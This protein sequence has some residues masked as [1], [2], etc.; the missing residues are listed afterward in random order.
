M[1]WAARFV[2]DRPRLWRWLAAPA[3][4]SLVLLAAIIALAF[5]LS[6][7][8]TAAL[9]DFGPSWLMAWLMP[10]IKVVL[11]LLFLAAGYFAFFAV[12][13]LVSSPFNEI[14]SEHVEAELTGREA[15]K[16]SWTVFARDLVLGIAHASRRLLGYLLI[17]IALLAVGFFVPVVGPL[18]SV[19]IGAVVTIRSAAYDALDAVWARKGWRYREKMEYLR[20]YRAR[21]LGLGLAVTLLLVVPIVN[22]LALPL[23]AVAATRLYLDTSTAEARDDGRALADRA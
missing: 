1:T 4:I 13:T 19:I 6:A 21:T 5:D 3:L 12:A 18:A 23:G 2:A 8:W 16:F 10:V 20:K 9:L 17:V 15:P 11:L 22:A 7:S 14:L